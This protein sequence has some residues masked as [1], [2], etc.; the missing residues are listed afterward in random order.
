MHLT[1]LQGEGL[2]SVMHRD[3]KAFGGSVLDLGLTGLFASIVN[4]GLKFVGNVT[5]T[6]YRDN[7]TRYDSYT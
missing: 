2:V 4:S 6:Y 5:S 7:L 3:I 1:Q